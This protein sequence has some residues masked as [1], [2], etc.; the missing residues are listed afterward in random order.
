VSSE[1]HELLA[2]DIVANYKPVYPEDGGDWQDTVEYLYGHERA[3]MEALFR[4]VQESGIREPLTL[5]TDDE[6]EA[7]VYN[8]THRV[9]MAL[10]HGLVTLPA[11]YGY[12]EPEPGQR[13]IRTKIELRDAD[14]VTKAE[15]DLIIDELFSWYLD[16]DTWLTANTAMGGA[17]YWE[18]YFDATDPKLVP[19]V[20]T[21]VEKF[22][23][24]RLPAYHFD[25]T[26]YMAQDDADLDD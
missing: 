12:L 7:R 3:R 22:L 25:V 17:T 8:G 19:K 11:R 20:K 4:S 23:R 5:S 6:F 9:A 10:Y 2:S 24:N 26:V 13:Y 16:A 15:D 18:L 21:A 14:S 1:I